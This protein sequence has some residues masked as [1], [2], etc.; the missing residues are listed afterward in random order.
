M[1]KI[2]SVSTLV[3]TFLVFMALS[4]SCCSSNVAQSGG[5]WKME[6]MPAQDGA[7]AGINVY[8]TKTGEYYQLYSDLKEK[9]WKKNPNFPTPPINITKGDIRMQYLPGKGALPGLIIYSATTGEWQQLYLEKGKWKIN[10]NFTSPK[11]TLKGGGLTMD[12]T[13]G[14]TST[15]PN[16]FISSAKTNKFEMLYFDGKVWKENT[17]FPSGK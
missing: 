6:Y 4:F 11:T 12:F 14:T 13:P 5:E 9:K 8:S 3:N 1:L 2:F 7:Y 17:A 15:L 10:P 16:L